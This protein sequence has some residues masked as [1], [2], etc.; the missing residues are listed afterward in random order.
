MANFTLPTVVALGTP[1]GH[2]ALHIIR[3]TGSK[4]FDLINK[5]CLYPVDQV[6]FKAQLNYIIDHHQKVIDQVIILKFVAPTT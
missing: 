1:K 3:I 5:V 2:G 4:A 6:N